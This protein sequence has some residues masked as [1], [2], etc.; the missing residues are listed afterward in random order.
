MFLHIDVSNNSTVL[1][2][3]V[4]V[5]RAAL[6]FE[7]QKKIV[8]FYKSGPI[9][10]KKVPVSNQRHHPLIPKSGTSDI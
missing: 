5:K 8:G 2:C 10:E 3:A 4:A 7:Q 9:A 6:S 1:A